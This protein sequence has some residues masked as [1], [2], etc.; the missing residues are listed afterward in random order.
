[1]RRTLAYEHIILG[2]L[3]AAQKGLCYA[4]IHRCTDLSTPTIGKYC[5][6]LASRGVV[7]IRPY[8]Q[9]LVVFLNELPQVEKSPNEPQEA[10][11]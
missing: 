3:R 10:R 6:R 9:A 8:G 11:T 1:M 5:E 2:A 7:C 4:D